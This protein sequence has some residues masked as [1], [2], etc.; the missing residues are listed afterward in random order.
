MERLA[1]RLDGRCCS[2]PPCTATSAG[3][4]WRPTGPTRGPRTAFPP[5]SCRTTT[6]ARGAAPCAA[7]TSRPTPGR[8]S[9]CGSRAGS[10]FDVVVDLRRGSPTF[11]EWEG[12]ELDDE[13]RPPAV[14]PGRLRPRLLRAL[15]RRGL[16]LQ[17]HEL[18]RP[19]D[20]GGLPLRRSRR[21]HR[22]ARR[23]SCS[24]PSA[25][26]ARRGW[27]RSPTRCRS[28][29]SADGRFAPSPTGDAAPREPAHRAAGV[30]VRA[31]G[32]RAAS[33]CGWRTST[34]AAC[35]PGSAE[36]QLADLAAIGL[37]W[38][39][40]VVFQS[41]RAGR[42]MRTRSSAARRRPRVRVLLHAGRDPRRRLGA[43]RAAA[44]GRLSRARAC[45]CRTPSARPSARAAAP[46][47][48]RV[49]AERRAGGVRGPAARAGR[50]ASST[51][52]W[53]AATTARPPTTSPSSSTTRR[54][55]SARS[56]AAPT[57]LDSTPRQLFLARAAR[58]CPSRRYAHVPL[59]LG[60][61]GARLAKRHGA[62]TLR[63]VPARRGARLDGRA[64]SGC[65]RAST[66]ADFDPAALPASRRRGVSP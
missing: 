49:R 65:R 29:V 53:C 6:R 11:G 37:D 18:L 39:G 42:C 24:T 56:C 32:R 10:V 64:R 1:T 28:R 34:P 36:E 20:R 47:A 51:T 4:S 61:D 57:S 30:A 7:S 21:R 13:Q 55:A 41:D 62:V 59:V 17:V 44:R 54:R 60:P 5:S 16:R 50:R 2:R 14:H 22:V 40:E 33:S 48:L 45:A 31:L 43:A 3:S 46:P 25:T 66:P 12:H 26:G 35:G 15:R 8:A 63:E 27:P 38:D 58:R 9:S 23:S 19:G 52:S